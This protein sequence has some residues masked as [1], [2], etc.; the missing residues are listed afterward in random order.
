MVAG[1]VGDMILVEISSGDGALSNVC[2]FRDESGAG[3]VPA[4]GTPGSGR[5]ALHRVRSS[6]FDA[7]GLDFG[8]LRFD[9]EVAATVTFTE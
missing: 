6:R 1:S 8:E 5:I 4:V 9:F 7:P 2:A 3:T